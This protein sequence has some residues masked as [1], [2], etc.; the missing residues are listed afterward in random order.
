MAAL[1]NPHDMEMDGEYRMRTTVIVVRETTHNKKEML[2]LLLRRGFCPSHWR[3]LKKLFESNSI[4]ATLVR[5]T[6]MT[7]AE[8]TG[9]GSWKAVLVLEQSK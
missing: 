7:V 1:D 5:I 4:D 9:L 2:K 6:S 8:F 3:Q